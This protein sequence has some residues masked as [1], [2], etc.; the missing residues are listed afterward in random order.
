MHDGMMACIG[1]FGVYS[2]TK[3]ILQRCISYP[4]QIVFDI[5]K[6]T[7]CFINSKG[8]V[9][10]DYKLEIDTASTTETLKKEL[11]KYVDDHS[12]FV[13]ELQINPSSISYDGE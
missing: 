3:K 2:Y 1:C 10:V 13:S 11:V 6:D 7:A 5:S 12:G 8:S 9:R 4:T